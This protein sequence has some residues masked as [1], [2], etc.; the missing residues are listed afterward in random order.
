MVQT[1]VFIEGQY[2]DEWIVTEKTHCF[3]NGEGTLDDWNDWE[4]FSE[5]PYP[6]ASLSTLQTVLSYIVSEKYNEELVGNNKLLLCITG[7]ENNQE[8]WWEDRK[9]AN[10]L[11]KVYLVMD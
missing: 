4:K 1:R 9:Y 6:F 3:I 10:F 7:N 8:I 11:Q 2:N 5:V